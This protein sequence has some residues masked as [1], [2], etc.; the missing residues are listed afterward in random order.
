VARIGH[1]GIRSNKRERG[2]WHDGSRRRVEKSPAQ[3]AECQVLMHGGQ[4]RQTGEALLCGKV[5]AQLGRDALAESRRETRTLER[6][7]LVP[8][9]PFAEGD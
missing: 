3:L 6:F 8:A 9:P 1:H 4:L 5:I 2:L 7:M